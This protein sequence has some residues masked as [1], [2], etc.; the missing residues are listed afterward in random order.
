MT[1]FN[2]TAEAAS[3]ILRSAEQQDGEPNLRV[4]A[5]RAEDGSILYGMGFD[6]RRDQDEVLEC[7]GVTVLIGPLSRDLLDGT[8]LDFVE[9][10]PGEYQFI[11]INPNEPD[12]AGGGSPSADNAHTKA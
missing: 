6:E 9:L 3:Q 2:L 5:K 1:R 11:F 7:A 8:S 10:A 12:A 4:A